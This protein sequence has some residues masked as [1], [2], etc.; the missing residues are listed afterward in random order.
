MNRTSWRWGVAAVLLALLLPSADADAVI[1][2]AMGPIQALI[3]VLPQILLALSAALLAL[4]KPRTY[5]FLASYLWSHKAFTVVLVGA[6]AFLIWGPS[7]SAGK[8]KAEQSGAPWSAFRGGPG[9]SGAVAGAKGFL[10]T[11]RIEWK[12]AG[13]P[14][15]GSTVAVD[16]SPA[17]VGNRLYF[18]AAYNLGSPFGSSGAIVAVDTDTG[19]VAWRWTGKGEL[20]TPLHPVFSSPAVWAE[21][22]EKGAPPAARWLVCGEGYHEDK[23]GRLVCLDLEPVRKSGGKE[24]PKLAWFLQATDHAEASPCIH[25]GKVLTGCGDDGVWCLE[26]ATGKVLWHIE[27]EPAEYE[28]AEG[29]KAAALAGLEGKTVAATGAVKRLNSGAKGKDDP[30][31]VTIDVREF[32]EAA[33]PPV[34]LMDSARTLDRTVFGRV[35]KGT[36]GVRIVAP[37]FNPDS[38]S[39]PVGVTLE[40]KEQRFIFGSGLGGQRVNC[41]NAE[42]GAVI[43]KT[44]TPYPAFGAPTI[45]GDKV[46]IGCGKGDFIQSAPDPAGTILCLSLKDGRELWQAK[47]A[48]TILG[49]IAVLEGRAYACSRDGNVY[50]VD[51]Q[52]GQGVQKMATGSPM[53]SSPVVTADSVY[54]GN[55]GGKVFAFDRRTGQLRA[56]IPLTPGSEIISSPAVSGGRLFIGTRAKGVYALSDRPEGEEAKVAARPWMGPGGDAGRTGCADDRGLPPLHSVAVQKDEMPKVE[57]QWPTPDNLNRPVAALVACG[58]AVYVAFEATLARVDAKTGRI[59]WEAPVRAGEVR[60]GPDVVFARQGTGPW[61]ALDA[62]TGLKVDRSTPTGDLAAHGLDFSVDDGILICRSDTRDATLWKASPETMA[63][64]TPALSGDRIFVVLKGTDK[65]KG[66]LE[67]RRLVDGTPL[68]KVELDAAATSHPVASSDYVAVATADEKIALFKTSDGGRIEPI[69][70]GG[71]VVAPALFQDTLIIASQEFI[72]CYDLSAKEHVWNYK[73]QLNIGMATGQPVICNETIWVGTT[74]RGLVAIGVSK[75]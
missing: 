33:A 56:S 23:D 53:V 61:I 47:T 27:G 45:A 52:N 30:G 72:A 8:A 3:V 2:S 29:P 16:S 44:P 59:A 6:V 1:P 73:D 14:L 51:L 31:Q 36:K 66:Y 20:P 28:V 65:A 7:F 63:F 24:P 50:V 12:L 25:E 57:A 74:K 13:D 70:V 15:G 11:P 54:V 43:W 40:N 49:S 60:A 19:A 71:P 5:K 32:K 48:D 21:P 55:N 42:T 34:P 62:T 10:A 9:R 69:L 75:K 41:V 58:T 22:P 18:G 38:E 68:W 37:F 26:L 46:L 4:F 67:A 17:V 35:E 64:P 39:S